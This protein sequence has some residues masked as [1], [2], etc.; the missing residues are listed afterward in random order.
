MV[1]IMIYRTV[2]P[3]NIKDNLIKCFADEWALITAGN[4]DGYNMMTASWGFFGEMWGED[5]VA[6]VVRPQRYTM[7]FIDKSDYFTVSFYGDKKD[8]HKICGS[9]SGRDTDKTKETGLSP[10]VNEKYVYFKEAR[11]V[12]VVKK[13]FVSRMS[14]ENFIDKQII[15][16][17]YPNEDYHNLIIGKIEKVLVAE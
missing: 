16:K 14:E 8:I 1:M 4:K 15:E 5:S 7:E 17:W 6:V 11:M 13:Q 2:E 12:I 10:V 3:K 9:K